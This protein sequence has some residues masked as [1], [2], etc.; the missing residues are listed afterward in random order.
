MSP[1]PTEFI[2]VANNTASHFGFQTIEQLRK[3]PECKNC[4]LKL[5]HTVS[6]TNKKLDNHHGLLSSAVMT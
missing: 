5:P 3:N 2:K 4:D 6:D 1:T